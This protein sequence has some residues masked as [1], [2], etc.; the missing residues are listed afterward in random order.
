MR[1]PMHEEAVTVL[2]LVEQMAERLEAA[3][4]S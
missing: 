1:P 4:L 3:G 2:A